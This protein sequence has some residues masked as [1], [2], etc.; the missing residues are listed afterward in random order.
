MSFD[1][2]RL[3]D[4]LPAFYRVRDAA[5]PDTG[6]LRALLGVIAREVAVLEENLAQ[7]YDDQF[8]E[9]CA[10]WAVPYLGDLL[11]TQL[12]HAVGGSG[13]S[14]RAQVANTIGYRRRK[15]T[16]AMLEQLARDSTGWD[17]RVVE[18]FSRLATTE[19]LGHLR[20]DVPALAGLRQAE[21][22]EQVGGPF[23]ELAHLADVRR[24]G[25]GRGRHNLPNVGIFLW[26]LAAFSLTGAPTV[27]VDDR[28]HQL[29]PLGVDQ[30]LVTRPETEPSVEHLAEPVNVPLPISRRLLAAHLDDYYRSDGS[31]FLSVDGEPVARQSVIACDLS[32][33]RG[34][35]GTVSGW[36]HRV[37]DKFAVDP[38][39]GRLTV[40]P[41]HAGKP[42]L[43]T[44]HRAFSMPMGGG[45]Y[46]RAASFETLDGDVRHLRVGQRPRPDR[47]VDHA[48]ITDALAALGAAD[49]VVEVTD[50]G[51]YAE[52]LTVSPAPGQRI[53][54]RA[55]DGHH[56]TVALDRDLVV[57]GGEGAAVTL[58]GFLV[59]GGALRVRGALA[60]LRLAHCTLVPGL[61]LTGAG[62]PAAADAPSLTLQVAHGRQ[63]EVVVEHTITGPL[64][65]PPD[66]CTLRLRDSIVD[67]PARTGPAT[68]VHA[69]VSGVPLG[70]GH[71]WPDRPTVTVTLGQEGPHPVVLAAPPA[72]LGEAATRLQL[73][74]RQARPDS[75]DFAD[76]RVVAVDDRLVVLAGGAAQVTIGAVGT[77]P[78]AARLGLL[79]PSARR[80]VALLGGPLGT[81]PTVRPPRPAVTVTVGAVGPTP[82][83]LGTPPASPEAARSGLQQAIRDARPEPGFGQALVGLVDDRLLVL[84][85][86]EDAAVVVGAADDRTTLA[87][88]ALACARPAVAATAGGELPGPPAVIERATIVGRVSVREL[89]LA[90]NTI[91]VDPVQSDRRQAGCVRFC[92]VPDGSRT[93]RRFRCQPP[94]DGAAPG[95]E[96]TS[97]RYGEAAYGQLGQAC[98][99]GITCGADDEGELGAFHDLLQPQ[100]VTN[101]LVSLDE[102]LRFSLEAGALFV[103]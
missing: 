4:L 66:R 76:A 26:R 54:L 14:R 96:F 87:D 2:E 101:L 77:D 41:E 10:E 83:A 16:A 11:G 72:D 67:S 28:R 103:T 94:P 92:F 102:F 64:R 100:R 13:F 42:V 80:V 47:P 91:F 82:V 70:F 37:D 49:G 71:P 19:H 85:G 61:A 89:T 31:L 17:A 51:R 24:I 46:G 75:P 86:Q 88:L 63:T 9:T 25:S 35:D 40:P 36:A 58:N 73:A 29:S 74:I 97:L 57:D 20:P 99:P 8:I 23:D 39:L 5:G 43:V 68:Q 18:Y 44:L 45:E 90:S 84:P 1:A 52:P 53:E 38:V 98:P 33:V 56:P 62:D 21:A 55:G 60:R 69:L 6:P 65:L 12:L 15:G 95:P 93:P 48:T 7:R 27:P 79:R 34:P 3:Y 22:L 50:S 30:Q 32:D 59:V 81:P 78:T